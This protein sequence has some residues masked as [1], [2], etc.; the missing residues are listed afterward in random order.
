MISTTNAYEISN[1]ARPS[2]MVGDALFWLLSG[3]NILEFDIQRQTLAVIEKPAEYAH[4]TGNLVG[5]RF[6]ILRREDNGLGLAVLSSG[7]PTLLLWAR[8]SNCD[9]VFSWVLQKTVQLDE[10]ISRLPCEKKVVVMTGYDEDTNVIFLMSISH[11]FMLE[12]NSMQFR[13]IG[14]REFFTPKTY[15]PYTN[16]YTAGNASSPN[17]IT[18]FAE[19]HSNYVRYMFVVISFICLRVY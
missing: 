5:M 17:C 12:L 15:Y 16:F 10:F 18:S 11:D 19:I 9:G 13:Y 7:P 1:V 3:A 4:V 8:D 6:Q 14:R 2:V